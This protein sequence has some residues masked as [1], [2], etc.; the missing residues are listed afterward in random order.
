MDGPVLTAILGEPRAIIRRALL[1]L[2]ALM[3]V[4]AP[5]LTMAANLAV[6]PPDEAAAASLSMLM[7]DTPDVGPV[8]DPPPP[9]VGAVNLLFMGVL[10]D[11]RIGRVGGAVTERRSWPATTCAALAS[12]HP[13]TLKRPPRS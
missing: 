8:T 10:P 5:S 13:G 1:A 3:L 2:A 11:E 12:R 4:S 7:D 9:L 6:A